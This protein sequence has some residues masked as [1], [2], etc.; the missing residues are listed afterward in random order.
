LKKAFYIFYFFLAIANTKVCA[1]LCTGSLGEPIVNITFGAGA[2]PANPLSAATTSYNYFAQDCPADGF[3]TVRNIT[4]GCFN[5]TWYALTAD[6][7]GDINGYCMI[8][9]ASLTPS[10]FYVD[11]VRG[12]CANSTYV[13]GAYILNILKP[14]AC[15]GVGVKPNIT[16][17]IERLDGTILGTQNTGDINPNSSVV[18][19]EYGIT[20]TT[21]STVNDV[22]LRMRN[23][24]V[25]GC[26][27]DLALDDITF[28]RCGPRITPT[29]G[30]LNT[31]TAQICA[32]I[33][34]SFTLNATVSAGFNNP[35]YQWQQSFNGAPFTD[36]A[37]ANN[38]SY[39]STYTG[40]TAIG[41][42]NL[43]LA[44]GE[45]GNISNVNCR[46]ISEPIKIIVNPKPV[47]TLSTLNTFCENDTIK[48]QAS[49]VSNYEWIGP[50]NFTSTT[51][52]VFIPNASLANGGLYQV[53]GADA[54][55]CKDT[56]TI[57]V[58]INNIPQA[59]VLFIDST[60]CANQRL[61]L[62]ASGGNRYEWMPNNN[63]SN[64]TISNPIVNPKENIIYTVKVFNQF[65]C[66]DTATVKINVAKLPIV[67][68]G[69]NKFIVG[70]GSTIL[71]GNIIGEFESYTWS[72]TTATLTN[73]NTLAPTASSISD[74]KILLTATAKNNCGVVTDEM[75]LKI[76]NGLY[77]P[78][79]FTPNNDGLNDL[80]N[81]PALAAYP[82][83][84]VLVYNRYGQKMYEGKL[85]SPSW[86]GKYKQ[87]LVPA[88]AYTYV[89][90]LKNGSSIL[91][92]SVLVLY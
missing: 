56:A 5:S 23:N 44:V 85:N 21:P 15:N 73:T 80:W 77:I 87:T 34:Q 3:Y 13:F 45:L 8:I 20:F 59:N 71:A 52:N 86:N 75:E 1:Q 55:N 37:G 79:T 40:N 89:I 67:D 16:F 74:A 81:I 17:T 28:R 26:G 62:F 33:N 41:T 31:T 51:N 2:N 69:P 47:V 78:N 63:I 7:T 61:Q 50:N 42:Y 72:S 35:V 30:G 64:T 9:N 68:A 83:H 46:I 27:N 29:I 49:G 12:L 14:T 76:Y 90:D 60:I 58:T 6:H 39:V 36:I 43:R 57:N 54:N 32:G 24:S 70:N 4:V 19:N 92:G 48:L 22:V 53:F 25:G 65:N 84:T 18:W 88:G 10:D 66:T 38:T 11:T 91:K 82:N